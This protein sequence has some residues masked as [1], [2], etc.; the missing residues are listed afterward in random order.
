MGTPNTSLAFLKK[1]TQ[2]GWQIAVYLILNHP[3]HC[4]L[5]FSC[6][7]APLCHHLPEL[8]IFVTSS[9][10]KSETSTD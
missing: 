9:K 4:G 6:S 7:V 8:L 10:S 2:F 1:S 5:F 3:N